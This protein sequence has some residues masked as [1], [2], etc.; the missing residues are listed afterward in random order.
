MSHKSAACASTLVA[1]FKHA[2]RVAALAFSL[3]TVELQGRNV[4]YVTNGL[5]SGPGSLRAAIGDANRMGGGVV[6]FHALREPVRLLSNLPPVTASPARWRRIGAPTPALSRFAV[7]P[8]MSPFYS[9][10]H[11][12][13]GLIGQH[14]IDRHQHAEGGGGSA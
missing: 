10:S 5:D 11:E 4:F 2:L 1:V 3:Q 7:Q 6:L 13:R 9:G 12:E 14:G 8:T